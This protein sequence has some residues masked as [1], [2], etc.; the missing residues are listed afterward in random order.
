MKA[1][2]QNSNKE[3]KELKKEEQYQTLIKLIDTQQYMFR[4]SKA[5]PQK[6]GQIDLSS[7]DNFLNVDG[8]N[9]TADM[10][11]F[12]RAYS[13]SLSLDGGI[14]FDDQM[15]SYEVSRNDK[16]R[17]VII[18]FKVNATY[19]NYNCTLTVTGLNSAS[20][21]VISNKRQ[22]ISYIGEVSALPNDEENKK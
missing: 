15:E 17:R 9:A 19:D 8:E 21:S 22:T 13:S 5:K 7:R 20:L 10:P 4:G 16:K 11:Y 6:G 12:G 14:N 18:K 1:T 3:A 2:A